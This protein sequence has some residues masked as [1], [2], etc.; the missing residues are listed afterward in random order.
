MKS[1]F[2]FSFESNLDGYLFF[3]FDA[4]LAVFAVSSS[5]PSSDENDDDAVEEVAMMDFFPSSR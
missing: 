3:F 4:P 5:F 1:L 2:T